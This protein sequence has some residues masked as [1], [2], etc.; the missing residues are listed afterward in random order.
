MTEGRERNRRASVQITA[1]SMI[2]WEEH[3]HSYA[4]RQQ[5]ALLLVDVQR[6]TGARHA[7]MHTQAQMSKHKRLC[8]I[9]SR[10]LMHVQTVKCVQSCA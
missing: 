2:Q 4:D 9:C 10:T 8:R 5:T 7:K 6:D 1:S 3:R